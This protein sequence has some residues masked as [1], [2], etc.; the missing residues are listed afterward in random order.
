[1]AILLGIAGAVFIIAMEFIIG[2]GVG[3]GTGY[4]TPIG[5]GTGTGG[6][7]SHVS[8]RRHLHHRRSVVEYSPYTSRLLEQFIF[9]GMW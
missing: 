4:G 6:G 9:A 5:V 7:S 2:A 1:M 3:V 8:F